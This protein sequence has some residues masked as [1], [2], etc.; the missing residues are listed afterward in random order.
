MSWAVIDCSVKIAILGSTAPPLS[1][2]KSGNSPPPYIFLLEIFQKIYHPSI[3]TRSRMEKLIGLTLLTAALFADSYVEPTAPSQPE[4]TPKDQ[5]PIIE[6]DVNESST[7][8]PI[9]QEPI[10]ESSTRCSDRPR[11]Y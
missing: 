10:D 7:N 2:T 6:S 1:T 9:D 5:A 8:A 4:E 3:S 11:T